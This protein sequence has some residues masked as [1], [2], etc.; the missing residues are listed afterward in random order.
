LANTDAAKAY[1]AISVLLTGPEQAVS[2]LKERMRP[3]APVADPKQLTR[4]IADLDSERFVV[5]DKAQRE[6]QRLGEPAIP[7][8]RRTLADQPSL[9]KKQ[10]LQNILAAIEPKAIPT[11]PGQLRQLR[12]VQVLESLA[13]PQARQVLQN[14]AQ[15]VAEV[16]LTREAQAALERLD[17]RSASRP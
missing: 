1:R 11:S 5:R 2:L 9:E 10:R 4:W 6:I 16:S 7:A 8:L 12:T 13:T 17:K 15:G 14:L 3:V